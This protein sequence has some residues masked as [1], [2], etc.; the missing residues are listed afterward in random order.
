MDRPYAERAAE[1]DDLRAKAARLDPGSMTLLPADPGGADGGF[2]RFELRLD[3]AAGGQ[4]RLRPGA[5]DED[6]VAVLGAGTGGL[7]KAAAACATAA[8]YR[9]E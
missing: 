2:R 8:Q 7:R 6:P 5:T 9:S 1:L 3:C 4:G